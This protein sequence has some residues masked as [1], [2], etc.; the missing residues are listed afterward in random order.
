VDICRYRLSRLMDGI[1]LGLLPDCVNKFSMTFFYLINDLV[2]L[3]PI[4]LGTVKDA[5]IQ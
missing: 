2:I 5:I 4:A 3:Y 1:R